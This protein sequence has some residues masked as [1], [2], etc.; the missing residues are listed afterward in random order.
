MFHIG[1]DTRNYDRGYM[2]GGEFIVD[3]LEIYGDNVLN[4]AGKRAE[5]GSTQKAPPTRSGRGRASSVPA[6]ADEETPRAR[7][8]RGALAMRRFF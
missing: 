5:N 3:R 2:R 6:A 4:A 8:G 1:I 7:I